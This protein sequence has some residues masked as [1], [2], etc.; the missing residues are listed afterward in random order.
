M[1]LL[2]LLF[3]SSS[4]AV[5]LGG[6][7]GDCL[8]EN[9]THFD[10]CIDFKWNAQR[11]YRWSSKTDRQIFERADLCLSYFRTDTENSNDKSEYVT[12]LDGRFVPRSVFVNFVAQRGEFS[13]TNNPEG[14]SFALVKY[15][16][17]LGQNYFGNF[18]AAS[19]FKIN[20]P[21]RDATMILMPGVPGK[22]TE[23]T[24]QWTTPGCDNVWPDCLPENWGMFL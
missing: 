11:L 22:A 20:W 2:W 6:P 4:H 7:C 16:T 1:L 15:R 19:W 9:G 17:D 24:D 21:Q 8:F 5:P 3:V 12:T 13:I 14:S 10:T 18:P 23:R